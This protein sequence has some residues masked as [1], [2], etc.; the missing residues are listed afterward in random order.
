M[1]K[2]SIKKMQTTRH[3]PLEVNDF[4]LKDQKQ[5]NT[6]ETCDAKTLDFKIKSRIF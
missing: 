5:K 1:I 6:I 3:F 4:Q 2:I